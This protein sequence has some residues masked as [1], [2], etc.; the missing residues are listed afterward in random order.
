MKTLRNFVLLFFAFGAVLTSCDKEDDPGTTGDPSITL[1]KGGDTT[2]TTGSTIT[3]AWDARKNP[4]GANLETFTITRDNIAISGTTYGGHDIPYTIGSADNAQ[5][6]DTIDL[7]VPQN[8]GTYVYRFKV[9]DKDGRVADQSINVTVEAATAIQTWTAKMLVAQ[10]NAA[11][12]SAFSTSTGNLHSASPTNTPADTQKTI[13]MLYG[14]NTSTSVAVLG[15]PSS[16]E[17]QSIY[18]ANM[19]G[20][21]HKNQTLFKVNSNV[22]KTDFDAIST[23]NEIKSYYLAVTGATEQKSITAAGHIFL[24]K[25]QAGKHGIL[26]VSDYTAGTDGSITIDVKVEE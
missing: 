18:S 2:V 4:N 19:A 25:T 12:S 6:V 20:W 23:G 15:A 1:L 24:F 7:T 5:Y 26:Y 13:D 11:P 21:T 8:A 10:D 9:T 16:S 17:I 22:T 3:V 14:V